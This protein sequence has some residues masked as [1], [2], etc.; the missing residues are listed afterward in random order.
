MSRTLGLIRVFLINSVASQD[1]PEHTLP[2]FP[3]I[4][5]LAEHWTV[6]LVARVPSDR[7]GVDSRSSQYLVGRTL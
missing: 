4:W 2:V 1:Y 5:E 7:V 6:S 3:G